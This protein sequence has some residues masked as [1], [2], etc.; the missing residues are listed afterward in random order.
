MQLTW[1]ED[2]T[3]AALVGPGLR[4]QSDDAPPDLHPR[5]LDEDFLDF[6]LHFCVGALIMR[7]HHFR[8]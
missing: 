4:V 5:V 6:D 8:H 1:V 3:G 7:R 2:G